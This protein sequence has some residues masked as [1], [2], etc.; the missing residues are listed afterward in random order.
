MLLSPRQNGL[1][2]LFKEVRVF[3]DLRSQLEHGNLHSS[4]V[5]PE[6]IASIILPKTSSGGQ[7]FRL[8]DIK[9]QR[10][11]RKTKAEEGRRKKE[12]GTWKHDKRTPFWWG[13]FLGQLKL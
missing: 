6:G 13:V 10:K 12:E 3:K 1:D 11:R 4:G 7:T 9:R 8:Q 2:S 5:Q